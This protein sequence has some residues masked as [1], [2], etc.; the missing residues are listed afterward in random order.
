[1]AKTFKPRVSKKD[2]KVIE[3][4]PKLNRDLYKLLENK[5]LLADARLETI[6]LKH[7]VVREQVRTKFNDSSLKELSENI[8]VN[9]LIQPLVVHYERGKYVLICG[10][11]RFRAMNLI[12]KGDAPCFVLENK[13]KEDLMSIQ[14]SENSSREQLHYIDRADGI[15]NYKKASGASERKIV[16]ALGISKTEVH[17]SLLI[18][19]LPKRVKEAAKKFDIE[20]YVL[21]EFLSLEKGRIKTK[22]EKLIL[23]GELVRRS[24][25]KKAITAGGVLEKRSGTSAGAKKAPRAAKK[26]VSASVF[27]KALDS[28]AK[29]MQLDKQTR[30]LLK[31]LLDETKDI[32]DL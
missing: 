16:A 25:I 24:E 15:L 21:L 3:Q 31:N 23:A 9:G 2:R 32:V 7:I 5:P 6:E 14:F 27:V 17:R 10:E 30:D 18:G 1:M 26:G 28:K 12:K 22:I 13:S 8:R 11:R 4:K 29:D 20:K 19:K